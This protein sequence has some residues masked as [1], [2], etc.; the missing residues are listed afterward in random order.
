MTEPRVAAERAVLANED[1]DRRRDGSLALVEPFTMQE[2]FPAWPKDWSVHF[3][4]LARG[5]TTVT[6][7]QQ[8]G[9]ISELKL[10]P[11][12]PITIKLKNPWPQAPVKV[13]HGKKIETLTGEILTLETTPGEMMTIHP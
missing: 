7:A 4:L 8:D 3:K 2:L 10:E 13:S 9:Q 12:R 11:T 5:G 6:A 1:R